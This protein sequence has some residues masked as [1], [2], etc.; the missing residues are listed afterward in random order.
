[1]SPSDDFKS[2]C[3]EEEDIEEDFM[4]W[5]DRIRQEYLAQQHARAQR[6]AA[7]HS[8]RRR[9]EGPSE[10]EQAKHKEQLERLQKEH[11]EY[12]QRAA[13]KQEE[14][15]QGKKQR[16]EERCAST[17]ASNSAGGSSQKQLSYADIP[18]PAQ[19][20]SVKD[21]LEVMLHGADRA[22]V[23]AF[24]KLLKRQQAIWHPDRFTQRCG[25]RLEEE[26]KQRILDTVTALSQELNSLAQSLR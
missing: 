9:R 17:F 23:P 25:E 16:Y 13:R 19:H 14:T 11:M 4:S 24:R 7:A 20:G 8:R 15:R 26:D 5:A 18:W 2:D 12:L 22:D 3:K 6:E 1:M 21:M 10:E